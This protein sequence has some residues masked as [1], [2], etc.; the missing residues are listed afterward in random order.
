MYVVLVG[1]EVRKIVHHDRTVY[2]Y[3]FVT[4]SGY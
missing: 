3:A 4:W 1:G 2:I